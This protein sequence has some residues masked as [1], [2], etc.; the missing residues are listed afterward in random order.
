VQGGAGG[1]GAPSRPRRAPRRRHARR[2][3]AT[4]PGPPP[5]ASSAPLYMLA[6]AARPRHRLLP[7]LRQRPRETPPPTASLVQ[8]PPQPQGRPPPPVRPDRCPPG[9]HTAMCRRLGPR[10]WVG[11]RGDWPG[12]KTGSRQGGALNA[13]IGWL[14]WCRGPPASKRFEAAATAAPG[15]SRTTN[16]SA[17]TAGSTSVA[18]T[19]TQNQG[20]GVAAPAAEGWA[21]VAAA[22]RLGGREKASWVPTGRD[23]DE[24]AATSLPF[25]REAAPAGRR[26]GDRGGGGGLGGGEVERTAASEAHVRCRPPAICQRRAAKHPVNHRPRPPPAGTPQRHGAR[27]GRREAPRR[28]EPPPPTPPAPAQR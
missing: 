18:T 28:L 20:G 9:P 27:P 15:T 25:R 1:E 6:P 10:G 3:V 7:R 12:E 16:A 8:A 21:A 26:T 13:A 11:G 24:G 4:A 19:P 17:G 5:R 14:A 2:R 23:G 22:R